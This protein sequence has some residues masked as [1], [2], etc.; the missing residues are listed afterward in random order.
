M[1]IAHAILEY[2]KHQQH[3]HRRP[4]TL[5]WHRHA[6]GLWQRYLLTEQHCVQLG[7]LTP[8]QVEHWLVFL[9]QQPRAT[10]ARRSA[11]TVESYARSVRAF[12]QWAVQQKKLPVTPFAHVPLPAVGHQES[13]LLEPDEWS[14]LLRACQP[15]KPSDE[16]AERAAARNRALLW[17]LFETGLRA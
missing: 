7:Q 13:P 1:T 3:Q 10:G 14:R 6:L 5:E 12:C 17:V 2:L 9:R 11:S 15:H 16:R 4:K 8:A